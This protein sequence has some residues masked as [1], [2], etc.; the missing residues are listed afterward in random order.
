LPGR[1]VNEAIVGSPGSQWVG[2]CAQSVPKVRKRRP[3]DGSRND[4]KPPLDDV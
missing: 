1:S 3:A 4:E 2:R